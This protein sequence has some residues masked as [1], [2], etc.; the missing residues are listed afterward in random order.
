MYALHDKLD[1]IS[2]LYNAAIQMLQETAHSI[3]FRFRANN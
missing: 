1:E 3:N 2:V